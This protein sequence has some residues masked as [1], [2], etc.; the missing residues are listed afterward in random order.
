MAPVS[1]SNSYLLR[2]PFG[3]STTASIVVNGSSMVTPP[4]GSGATQLVNQTAQQGHFVFDAPLE[5]E[6]I[7]AVLLDLLVVQRL[8][9]QVDQERPLLLGEGQGRLG[10]GYWHG[11][12]P[13]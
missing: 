2:L 7:G 4:A 3:V 6:R 12:P 9:Q 10:H 5:L 13:R 11:T 8:L 1:G